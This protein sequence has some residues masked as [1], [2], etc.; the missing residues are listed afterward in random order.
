MHRISKDSE[1]F[2]ESG[3]KKIEQLRS[4]KYVCE[5]CVR[6]S[7]PDGPW[8]D[9]PVALFY[10]SEIHPD[11]NSRYF[12]VYL[13]Q[14]DK[15]FITNGQ[16]AVDEPITGIIAD[17]GEIIYSRYRHDFRRSKDGSV[18]IDGGR[19]YYRGSILPEDRVVTLVIEQ[20][21]LKVKED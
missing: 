19:D 6:T 16:S 13:N 10:G 21:E 17:D 5:T 8:A 3:I 15:I 9:Q 4:A 20:G 14:E 2:K 11:S 12:G 7:Y 1:I 18:F